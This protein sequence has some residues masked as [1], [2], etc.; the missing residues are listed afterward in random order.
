MD[1][2]SWLAIPLFALVLLWPA[3]ASDRILGPLDALGAF[4]PWSSA[5]PEPARNPL[6]LDQAIATIPW[7]GRAAEDLRSGRLPIWNQDN[8]LGHPLHAAASGAFLFPL[9]FLY[10]LFPGLQT[11]EWIAFGKLLLAGLFLRGFLRAR[12][13]PALAATLGGVA[14]AGSGFLIAW[15]GHPHTNVAL[16]LPAALWCVERAARRADLRCV[17]WTAL[18]VGGV[19]FGG[20][21]QTALHASLAVAAY[22]AFRLLPNKGGRTL[23]LGGSGALLA[24]GLLG[25]GI[26]AVQLWPTI[27]YL[28]H[29]RAVQIFDQLDTTAEIGFEEAAVLLVDPNAYGRPD[30]GNYTGPAGDNLNYNELIGGYV[31]R[32]ALVL[33]LLGLLSRRSP[34]DRWFFAAIGLFAAAIAWQLPPLYELARELGPLRR[35]KLLRLL[36]LV[37]LAL[38]VLAAYGTAALQRAL[39]EKRGMPVG[40]L[41]VFTV[42]FELFL[43]GRGYQ[44]A[45][46]P[47]RALPATPL[48][49]YFT[50]EQFDPDTSRV[51]CLDNSTLL[52]SANLLFG[53]PLVMGYDS[54]EDRYIA[55]L[56]GLLSSDPRA[57]LFL[58]EIR[59]FDRQLPLGSMLGIDHLVANGPLPQPFELVHSSANGP[60][61]YRNPDALPQWFFA[62]SVER[63]DDGQ[64]RLA[65]LG[66]VDYDPW[67]GIVESPPAPGF[68]LYGEGSERGRVASVTREGHGARLALE[69]SEPA[70]LVHSAAH[71]PGWRAELDGERVPIVRTNHA[72]RGVWVPAGEH[73]LVLRYAPLS[74]RLGAGLSAFSALVVLLAF[75]GPIF[76]R[77]GRS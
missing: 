69:V 4:E 44:P 73:E 39:G 52:P 17:G 29:S 3:I 62:R 1:R 75:L 8:Y 36:L 51:L 56:V 5:N 72:L 12:D 45:V 67:L 34:R 19:A 71:T 27:E 24:G 32:V 68:E 28:G 47:E 53:T 55:E 48:T 35:T 6:L 20:H 21:L 26:G 65:R 64:T 38:S 11:F 15:L 58:K 74:L 54:I 66:A 33:A 50:G 10:Y 14:F 18:V 13:L 30:H 57:E 25:L 7:H 63:I 49:D 46:I 77:S 76:R 61:V 23:G 9:T 37:A 22:A 41:A 42:G 31:G 59:T 40:A 16:L 60:A 70:L 2:L 43:F